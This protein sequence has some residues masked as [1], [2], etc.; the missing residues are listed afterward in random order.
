MHEAWGSITVLQI[1]KCYK[2]RMGRWKERGERGEQG[3]QGLFKY[4]GK[5]WLSFKRTL[6]GTTGP[7]L[8][9]V[10]KTHWGLWNRPRASQVL[11]IMRTSL[12]LKVDLLGKKNYGFDPGPWVSYGN[13]RS[14]RRELVG[15]NSKSRSRW[16]PKSKCCLAMGVA[17][18]PS[19]CHPSLLALKRD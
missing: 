12:Y 4:C 19:H 13:S 1:N 18:T 5:P 8:G 3:H 10:P 7:E 14:W 11:L 16:L 17:H 2:I 6:K 9:S 15:L